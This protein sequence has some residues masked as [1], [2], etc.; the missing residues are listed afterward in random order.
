MLFGLTNVCGGMLP[1]PLGVKPVI[2]VA[3][4]AVQLKVVPV[5]LLETVTAEVVAPLQIVCE[6]G[7]ITLG[8]GSTIIS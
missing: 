8:N 1:L 4:V 7:K 6:A 3:L 5:T 2:P